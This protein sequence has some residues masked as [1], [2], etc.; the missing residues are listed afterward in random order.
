MLKNNA[1]QAAQANAKLNKNNAAKAEQRDMCH[2][3]SVSRQH[4]LHTT[5]SLHSLCS[6]R[7]STQPHVAFNVPLQSTLPCAP[8][9]HF[10]CSD[11]AK[12]CFSISSSSAAAAAST[13]CLASISC[14]DSA[15]AV[16][17]ATSS[18][19][20]EADAR[21]PAAAQH[22]RQAKANAT[23]QCVFKRAMLTVFCCSGCSDVFV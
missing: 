17:A 15:A 6:C 14:S 8:A 9:P 22:S 2:S 10:V 20:E 1:A 4:A 13:A 16:A 19:E 7:T 3:M 12:A 21:G 18:S 11:S 5:A 23:R